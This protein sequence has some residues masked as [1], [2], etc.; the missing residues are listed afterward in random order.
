[1]KSKNQKINKYLNLGTI[2]VFSFI[3]TYLL[4]FTVCTKPT[5]KNLFFNWFGISSDKFHVVYER[6]VFLKNSQRLMEL[7][8]M[9]KS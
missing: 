5:S 4:G 8:N 2:S 3:F 7:S 6:N 9:L 1:M